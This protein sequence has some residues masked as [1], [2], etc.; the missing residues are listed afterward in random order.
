MA[1]PNPAVLI[2][3]IRRVGMARRRKP[4]AK[5]RKNPARRKKRAA[6]KRPA[7]RKTARKTARRGTTSRGR[8]P[9]RKT[10]RRQTRKAAAPAPKAR[11]K[12][13]RAVDSASGSTGAGSAYYITTAISYPNGPPHIGH[14]Y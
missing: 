7:A 2:L 11:L 14:A 13:V 10:A 9:K 6:R 8:K 1:G 4:S 3:Q 12:Q 5:K